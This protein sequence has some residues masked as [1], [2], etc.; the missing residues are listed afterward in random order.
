MANL[1]VTFYEQQCKQTFNTQFMQLYLCLIIVV[2]QIF[3]SRDH[4]STYAYTNFCLFTMSTQKKEVTHTDQE[5]NLV[6]P[7]GRIKNGVDNV[8]DKSTETTT[9]YSF[10][11]H[12]LRPENK[13]RG[14]GGGGTQSFL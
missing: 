5:E 13:P 12:D 3:L 9:E 11:H 7:S 6:R 4:L 14:G 1:I 10:M 2:R 8:G